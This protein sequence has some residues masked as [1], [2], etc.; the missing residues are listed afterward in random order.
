[1]DWWTRWNVSGVVGDPTVATAEKGEALFEKT[2]ASLI[3]LAEEYRDIPVNERVDF[4]RHGPG[5]ADLEA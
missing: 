3:E 5:L 1:M 4:H 2:V